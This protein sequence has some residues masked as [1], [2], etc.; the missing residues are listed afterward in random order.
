MNSVPEI[1]AAILRLPAA[2]FAQLAQWISERRERAWD[3]EIEAHS[4]AG[5]FDGII[6][7]V[8]NEIARGDTRPT[9][10]L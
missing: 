6:A 9:D 3:D 4:S 7:E 1:E 10:E 2:D 5:L 8:E